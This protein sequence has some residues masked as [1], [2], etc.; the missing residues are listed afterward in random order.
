MERSW[1]NEFHYGRKNPKHFVLQIS[2]LK[3]SEGT[4][5]ATEAAFVFC[6]TRINSATFAFTL[7]ACL[8]N[9]LLG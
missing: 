6:A 5:N 1:K 2:Y 4:G 7:C 9:H 8:N 3:H